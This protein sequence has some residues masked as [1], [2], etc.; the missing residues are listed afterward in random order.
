MSIIVNPTSVVVPKPC[1]GPYPSYAIAI[2]S[3]DNQNH[4]TMERRDYDVT[5]ET[6]NMARSVVSPYSGSDYSDTSNSLKM[7]AREIPV[8][9]TIIH[10]WIILL[11][12]TVL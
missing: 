7:Q 1:Q 3:R 11:S 5:K 2:T 12:C 6:Y 8:L 9:F 10:A 4:R